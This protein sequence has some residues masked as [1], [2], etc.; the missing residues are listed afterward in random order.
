[1]RKKVLL[2]NPPKTGNR[3]EDMVSYPNMGILSLIA[4]AR[5][6]MPDVQ[7]IYMETG[8]PGSYPA[9]IQEIEP[10]LIGMSFATCM[11]KVAYSEIDKIKQACPEI[12]VV[13]GGPHPTALPEDVMQNSQVDVCVVGEGEATF[14]E[15]LEHYLY[16][17]KSLEEIDGLFFR[18]GE[19]IIQ[20][21]KR[22]FLNIDSIPMPAWDIIDFMDYLGA[23]LRRNHPSTCMVTNRGCPFN[24]TFCSN[25]VWKSDKPWLRTRS[26]ELIAEEV[27]YL[28][29]RGIREIYF[30]ADEF[31]PTYKWCIEVCQAIASLGLKDIT[32]QCNLRADEITEELAEALQSI[33]CWIVYLGIESMN[34]RVINGIQKYIKIEQIPQCCRI[35]HDHKMKVYGFMMLYQ[36]WEENG[37]LAFE[38]PEEVDNTLRETNKLI[39]QGLLDYLSWQ[40]ATPFP[41]SQLW[42]V[43]HKYKIIREDMK[44]VWNVSLNLPGVSER[45]MIR[46][47][48]LGFLLQAKCT[49][50]NGHLNLRMWRRFLNKI[51]YIVESLPK[52]LQK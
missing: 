48:T 25:P 40:F 15:L 3:Q 31:N 51:F 24:C 6:R 23:H 16:G 30:R 20:T 38:M 28:Y 7:F 45:K 21:K 13:C 5:Q 22:A 2:T 42:D 14:V 43:A 47:R 49:L 27:E 41:G 18:N 35:L 17:S 11:E 1:M 9:R 44:G 26:P 52:F 29:S 4:Y 32:F 50:K 12:P 10:N 8:D 36:A 34:Q 37:E 33:N 19:E 39:N 46:Q